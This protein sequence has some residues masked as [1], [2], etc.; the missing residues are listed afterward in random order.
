MWTYLIHIPT[1]HQVRSSFDKWK[2]QR[3]ARNLK[4][5][6]CR[7]SGNRARPDQEAGREKRIQSNQIIVN[8]IF[9]VCV[10]MGKTAIPFPCYSIVLMRSSA[11]NQQRLHPGKMADPEKVAGRKK[12]PVQPNDRKWCIWSLRGHGQDRRTFSVL[13]EHSSAPNQHRLHPGKM[14]NRHWQ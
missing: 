4:M 8:G 14:A 13:I 7:A 9:G 6:K 5:F 1:T 10:A 2:L 12:I 11:P 3:A